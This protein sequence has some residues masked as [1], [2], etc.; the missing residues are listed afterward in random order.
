[1]I[2]FKKLCRT[3]KEKESG[4]RVHIYQYWFSI[5]LMA[6]T[7]LIFLMY[8]WV[9][10][11]FQEI[12]ERWNEEVTELFG[13]LFCALSK[14][15]KKFKDLIGWNGFCLFFTELKTEMGNQFFTIPQ[16]IL[17][18]IHPLIIKKWFDASVTFMM[19]LLCLRVN[20]DWTIP[21]SLIIMYWTSWF[22]NLFSILILDLR[23]R[24]MGLRIFLVHKDDSLKRLSIDRFDRLRRGDPN[25]RLPQYASQKIRY[26]LVFL[27]TKDRRAVGINY[28]GLSEI[29]KEFIARN[30]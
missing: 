23:V 10:G 9:Y 16:C 24:V 13:G 20:N 29:L 26:A 11:V 1:M 12:K 17:F 30:Y 4:G 8:L 14:L 25:A 7:S 2:F 6:S 27:E 22:F 3:I 5:H 19:F 28:M 21:P 18:R 15:A